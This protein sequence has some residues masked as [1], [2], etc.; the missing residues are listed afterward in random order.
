MPRV[1]YDCLP[2]RARCSRCSSAVLLAGAAI[3]G[4]ET[5]PHPPPDRRGDRNRTVADRVRPRPVSPAL[6]PPGRPPALRLHRRRHA[7]PSRRS[8]RARN[9]RNL[10]IR[11]F[12]NREAAAALGSAAAIVEIRVEMTF[13]PQNVFIGVPGYDVELVACLDRRPADAAV[14]IDAHSPLRPA[15][16]RAAPLPAPA[17][18]PPNLPAGGQPLT[19][20]TIVATFPIGTL[21][22]AGVY[23]VVVSEMGKELARARVNFAGL[24]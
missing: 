20:G 3:A 9:A 21:D 5:G 23:D 2:W 6:S 4:L 22:A 1:R 19:G 16:R 18:G 12:T 7:F 8:D 17:G 24:R 14:E 13:H 11:G 15:H 10:G